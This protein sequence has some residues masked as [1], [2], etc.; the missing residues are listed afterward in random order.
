MDNYDII[1]LCIQLINIKCQNIHEEIYE[2]INTQ[3][4]NSIINT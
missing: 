2:K 3:F 4:F 1:Q